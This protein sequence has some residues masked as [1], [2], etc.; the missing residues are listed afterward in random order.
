M[1]L[2]ALNAKYI[3][4]NIALRLIKEY[5][6]SLG[7]E[8]IELAEYTINNY[9]EE[10]LK[11]IY[12]SKPDA[13]AFSCYI[14]NIEI[15][16]KIAAIL[17]KI[18]PEIKI[19]FGGP[20]VTYNAKEVLK[21]CLSCDIV[22]SGEGEYSF[23]KLY[24]SLENNTS[25]SDVPNILYR[26]TKNDLISNLRCDP[27]DMSVLPFPYTDF[28]EIENKI[29]Y[30]EASRGCPFR[31][32]YCLSSVENGVRFAPISKV[33]RELQIFLDQRVK[34]VKFVD[35]TF[36]S[37]N[38]FAVE[39]VKYLIKNDN[40]I[41][42]FHFE[43]AAEL[44]DDEFVS[45]LGTAR[46]GLFQLE[47]GVQSTN[48]DTLKSISRI[49]TFEKLCFYVTKILSY[50]NIHIHLDLIAGLPCE[51]LKS[52]EKS[53]N[54]VYSL[55][56]HQFQLGFLKILH[57]SGMEKLCDKY[58]I[59]YSPFAPY[60]VLSTDCLSY[61]DIL[62]LKKIEDLIDKYYNSNRFVYS[63]K[64]LVSH[65]EDAFTLYSTLAKLRND[66]EMENLNHNKNDSY[67]FLMTAAS[68]IKN[69][70]INEFKWILKLDY[71][72]H[73]RPRGIPDWTKDCMNLFT[74]DEVYY[75]I[76][77]RNVIANCYPSL[78]GRA[79]KELFEIS[80]TE[81][82]PL[83]PLTLEK[84]QTT[85]FINYSERNIWDNAEFFLKF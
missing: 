75:Q 79:P 41:T 6:V 35:R 78:D 54:D 70:D 48:K 45:L 15:I 37:K 74:K 19:I 32:Q 9:T 82:M 62:F 50:N 22:I 28:S 69:I 61:D 3:H 8:N 59:L 67:R 66:S 63:M 56:P 2:C 39:I 30:Y 42:N 14:W 64:Y 58:K 44:L 12:L 1:L 43:V 71:L 65:F 4:T 21:N 40:G 72:L 49:G 81:K 60:E 11:N 25:L 80:Y 52:F 38:D 17:K 7:A 83:N 85:I 24:N 10:I 76:V 53:F 46:K 18:M 16:K 73:E 57:G 77:H 26:N 55:S 27:L 68:K 31:C 33:K 23:Y 29:C 34:Q 47:I 51:G 84:K 5:C 20:E 36:N 13:V